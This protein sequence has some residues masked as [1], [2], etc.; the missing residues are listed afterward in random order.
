VHIFAAVQ[1]AASV[2]FDLAAS[3]LTGALE[4][5][6]TNETRLSNLKS[7]CSNVIMPVAQQ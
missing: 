5:H 1:I 6:E 7:F 4:A 3:N 2:T